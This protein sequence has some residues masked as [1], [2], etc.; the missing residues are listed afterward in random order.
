MSK[1]SYSKQV[2][3]GLIGR[4]L[5]EDY[6]H[7]LDLIPLFLKNPKLELNSHLEYGNSLV[8]RMHINDLLSTRLKQGL[9]RRV[10]KRLSLKHN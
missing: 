1:R 3:D 8:H 9:I 2:V 5:E 10:I 4:H 7:S 6:L